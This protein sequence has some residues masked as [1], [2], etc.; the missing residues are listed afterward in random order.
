VPGRFGVRG[1]SEPGVFG[2][3]H[4]LVQPG[5]P[6]APGALV[7][8]QHVRQAHPPVPPGLLKGDLARLEQPF[9]RGAR[10]DFWTAVRAVGA[11]LR[12]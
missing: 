8:G 7:I 5:G 9:E 2:V 4:H 12:S 3:R 10:Y 11:L 6:A 1:G